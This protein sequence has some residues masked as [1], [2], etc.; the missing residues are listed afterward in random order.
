MVKQKESSLT[1]WAD[2]IAAASKESRAQRAAQRAER[3]EW[4]RSY[5]AEDASRIADLGDHKLMSWTDDGPTLNSKF[6][7]AILRSDRVMEIL[8][9]E[10]ARR[11]SFEDYVHG[12]LNLEV[13]E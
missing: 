7:E 8:W 2:V 12:Y 5:F 1:D 9:D 13:S 4:L 10:I 6:S 3:N 11:A